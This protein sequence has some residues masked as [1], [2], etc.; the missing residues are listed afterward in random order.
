MGEGILIYGLNVTGKRQ[1]L[2]GQTAK[3]YNRI[4]EGKIRSLYADIERNGYSRMPAFHIGRVEH[5]MSEHAKR[6][7]LD[8]ETRRIYM[9][10][11]T[12][13]HARRDAKRAAGIDVSVDE[14][15]KFPKDRFKMKLLYDKNKRNYLYVSK[16]AKFIINTR[17]KMRLQNGRS[18]ATIFITAEKRHPKE[19]FNGKQYEV[20][21]MPSKRWDSNPFIR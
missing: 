4:V 9:N 16:T 12:L 7:G 3:S 8:M 13:S 6:D 10:G 15:A 2:S 11:S 1:G 18:H 5:V 14:L 21:R 17:G 19:H 20:V